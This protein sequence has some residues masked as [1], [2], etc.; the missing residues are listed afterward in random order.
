MFRTVTGVRANCFPTAGNVF[1]SP[2]SAFSLFDRADGGLFFRGAGAPAYGRHRILFSSFG[3]FSF[4]FCSSSA[5]LRT[6]VFGFLLF[7]DIPYSP[8][9]HVL[10]RNGHPAI[11]AGGAGRFTALWFSFGRFPFPG[12]AAIFLLAM[13]FCLPFLP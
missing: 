6:F 4:Y 7:F 1:L 9:V 8:R 12:R 2:E 10:A 5:I 11:S 3:P 13:P